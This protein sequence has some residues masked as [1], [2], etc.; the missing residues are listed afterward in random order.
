MAEPTYRVVWRPFLGGSETIATGL[1]LGQAQAELRELPTLP[2]INGLALGGSYGL[3]VEEP[4]PAGD[5]PS[6]GGERSD[7]PTRATRFSDQPMP[8]CW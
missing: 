5:A 2:V 4:H 1:T 7:V 3:E 8:D 6:L